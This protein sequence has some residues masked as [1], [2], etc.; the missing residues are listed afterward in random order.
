MLTLRLHCAMALRA[1][2]GTGAAGTDYIIALSAGSR[3]AAPLLPGRRRRPVAARSAT[4]ARRV[5]RNMPA[6][7]HRARLRAGRRSRGRQDSDAAFAGN[8]TAGEVCLPGSRVILLADGLGQGAQLTAQRS[9]AQRQRLFWI[10]FRPGNEH[11]DDLPVRRHAMGS[12][13]V[14]VSQLGAAWLIEP[15][16][17][18]RVR[19]SKHAPAAD[20]Q[21]RSATAPPAALCATAPTMKRAH[22]PGATEERRRA[23]AAE[24]SEAAHDT[25]QRLPGRLQR[26]ARRRTHRPDLGATRTPAPSSSLRSGGYCPASGGYADSETSL[27]IG[28]PSG[29]PAEVGGPADAT[30]RLR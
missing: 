20:G 25:D 24:L 17:R 29:S 11:G 9:R 1:A 22:A 12:T 6:G 23:S 10:C 4:T 13:P 30:G 5:P 7:Q 14:P 2:P 8:A 21:S 19:R 18:P 27:R 3:A 16:S 28:G 15:S 26:N